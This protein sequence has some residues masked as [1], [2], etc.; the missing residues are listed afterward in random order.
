M[1]RLIG[2]AKVE[3]VA[4]LAND[5]LEDNEDAKLILFAHHREVIRDLAGERWA[6]SR[7]S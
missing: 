1:R 6:S 3:G 5:F 7:L 2:R 4:A